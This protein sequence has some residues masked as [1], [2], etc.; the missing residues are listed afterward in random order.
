MKGETM[1]DAISYFEKYGLYQEDFRIDTYKHCIMD[2]DCK[3]GVSIG[4]PQL[5][6]TVSCH[7]EK[8]QV[9]NKTKCLEMLKLI[10]D[11]FMKSVTS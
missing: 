6:I 10:V 9:R 11:D 7:S 1:L 8:S 2:A 5:S 3:W 4:I